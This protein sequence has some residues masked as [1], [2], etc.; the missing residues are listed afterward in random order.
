MAHVLVL[1]AIDADVGGEPLHYV[2][3]RHAIVMLIREVAVAEQVHEHLSFGPFPAPVT[4]RLTRRIDVGA[5]AGRGPVP[6][7]R[8]NVRRRD[9][10]CAYCGGPP[11]TVDHILPSSRGGATSWMNLVAACQLCNGFK[12]DRTPAEAGMVLHLTPFEPRTIADLNAAT[13]NR[14]PTRFP[15]HR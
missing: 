9:G 12:D 15:G 7:S 6:L 10:E 13:T 2:T 4:L 11:T 8:E 3:A 1:N 5:W 14:Q